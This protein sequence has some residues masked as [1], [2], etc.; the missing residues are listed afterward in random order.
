[1][2]L[3][4]SIRP[5]RKLPGAPV[6]HLF[7]GKLAYTTVLLWIAFFAS[8]YLLWILLSWAPTLLRKSGATIQQYSL[9]F[10]G[11]NLGSAVA[12]ITIGRLMDK[13]NPFNILK[14]AFIIAFVSVV[15]FGLFAGSPF[16]VIAILSVVTGFFVIGG[17]SGLMGLATVSYPP[18]IRGTG[19]GWA[20]GIG[21]IGAMLAPATGGFLLSQNW[22]VAQ[23]CSTNALTALVVTAVI[24]ILHKHVVK[25]AG[26]G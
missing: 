25:A 22:S 15:V 3:S 13:S 8:F 14:I 20:Y 12:T 7:T 10:A 11:I 6:K 24:M 5:K 1:M 9:A 26:N 4:N 21:K 23:I 16:I 18:D 19:L 2:R 17:N